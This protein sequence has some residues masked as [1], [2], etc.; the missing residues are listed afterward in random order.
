MAALLV[1]MFAG[2]AQAA[3]ADAAFAASIVLCVATGF[4]TIGC[5]MY[6]LDKLGATPCSSC[7]DLRHKLTEQQA[8]L[9]YLRAALIEDKK[10]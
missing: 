7:K 8:D 5:V 4:G 3:Y 1:T 2:F 10:Q 6:G 9:D